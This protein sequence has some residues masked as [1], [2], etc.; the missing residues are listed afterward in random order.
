[1]VTRL[2][3]TEGLGSDAALPQVGTVRSWWNHAKDYDSSALSLGGYLV[4][5]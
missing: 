2:A 4:I 5:C 3:I 1:M